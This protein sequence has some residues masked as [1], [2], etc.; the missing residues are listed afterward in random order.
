MPVG[1]AAAAA[2]GCV[3]SEH[4]NRAH[5]H[6]CVKHRSGV[7]V[8]IFALRAYVRVNYDTC[9]ARW[10]SPCVVV[11][12]PP[13]RMSIRIN[14]VSHTYASIA[15]ERTRRSNVGL[16]CVRPSLMGATGQPL[17]TRSTVV[18]S[19]TVFVRNRLCELF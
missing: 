19:Q 7:C 14:R 2:A 11:C 4:Q 9:G 13:R 8:C 6:R 16:R 10:R 5:S 18:E 3:T 15:H 1:D 17:R 12:S